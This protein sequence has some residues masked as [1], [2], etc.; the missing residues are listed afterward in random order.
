MASVP[1]VEYSTDAQVATKVESLEKVV[2][3]QVFPAFVG[4]AAVAAPEL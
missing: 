4:L 2:G 3:A 1:Q